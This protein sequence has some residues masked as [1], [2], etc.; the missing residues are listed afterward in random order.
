[1]KPTH[2]HCLP[3]TDALELT[4]DARPEERQPGVDPSV[5]EDGV[6]S[7]VPL[8]D[9][10]RQLG[11][12]GLANQ[13]QTGGTRDVGRLVDRLRVVVVVVV[14][15]IVVAAAVVVLAAVVVVAA[16]VDSVVVLSKQLIVITH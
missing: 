14:V 10:P 9:S 2:N 8:R 11:Q 12:D 7:W 3:S 1:M 4:S 5:D 15:V 6:R 16:I 13:K